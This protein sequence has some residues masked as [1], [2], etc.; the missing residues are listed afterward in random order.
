MFGIGMVK[1]VEGSE[2]E[3]EEE[4]SRKGSSTSPLTSRSYCQGSLRDNLRNKT[5]IFSS[6]SQMII[7]IRLGIISH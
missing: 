3:E 5:Q 6:N 1:T 4:V 2:K 7:Y